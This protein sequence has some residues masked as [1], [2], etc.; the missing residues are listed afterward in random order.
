[1]KDNNN[2]MIDQESDCESADW[3]DW[4]GPIEQQV[5]HLADFANL[6]KTRYRALSFWSGWM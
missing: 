2:K 5:K 1:M 4:Q 6:E 3:T